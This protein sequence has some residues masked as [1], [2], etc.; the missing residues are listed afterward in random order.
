[1][2]NRDLHEL[3]KF[4]DRYSYLYFEKGHIHLHL[5]S[6]GFYYL[7]KVVPIPVETINLLMLGPGTTITQEAVKRIAEARCLISWVGES[8]V[9]FYASGYA[10][11]YSSKNMLA[12][13]EKYADEK[14]R[15]T[16]QKRMYQRRFPED[17]PDSVTI[18]QLRGKEGY[19][20]R[21]TYEEMAEKYE[22]EWSGRHYDQGNWNHA[23]PIN[24]ALSAANATLYG[25]VHAAILAAGYS[26]A[27]G[28]VHTGKQ[29]SF[30]YDI[31]DLYKTEITIPLAFQAASENREHLERY[32]R[33]TLRDI[34]REQKI[35]KRIIPDIGEII[36]GN[37]YSRKD[38]AEHQGRDV[39]VNC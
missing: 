17:L 16:V 24:R 19:R 33:H 27:I 1:M 39:A 4:E 5:K 31:A 6:I 7:D 8:G 13:I 11:T 20:V 25:I 28:F 30:V 29:L 18:E 35:L 38:D 36:F 23:D 32:V 15:L 12:Q 10:G 14:K 21:K 34:F 2:A 22:V 26:P 3:P 9:R 37:T